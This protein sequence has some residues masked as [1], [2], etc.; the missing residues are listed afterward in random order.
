MYTRL[1]K[2]TV[3]NNWEVQ[4]AAL[5]RNGNH[6]QQTILVCNCFQNSR[7]FAITELNL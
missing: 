6:L 5:S 2:K 4:L 1:L 3:T 7:I